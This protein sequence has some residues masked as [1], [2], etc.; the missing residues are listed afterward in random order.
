M[1][2]QFRNFSYHNSIRGKEFTIEAE[3]NRTYYLNLVIG[4]AVSSTK[5]KA[6]RVDTQRSRSQLLSML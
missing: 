3:N 1:L 5:S 4:V 2:V 6:V